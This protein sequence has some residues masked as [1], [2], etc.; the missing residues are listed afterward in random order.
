MTGRDAAPQVEH[1]PYLSR[2]PRMEDHT[3][4]RFGSTLWMDTFSSTRHRNCAAVPFRVAFEV[5]DLR[6]IRQEKRA[7]AR[8]N[9]EESVGLRFHGCHPLH[10]PSRFR[11]PLR[12]PFVI[13]VRSELKCEY[14]VDLG[15]CAAD[16]GPAVGLSSTDRYWLSLSRD[17]RKHDLAH[18]LSGSR[19]LLLQLCTAER[20]GARAARNWGGPN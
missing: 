2:S 17:L 11:N 9:S 12:L 15:N 13:P 8:Y 20:K 1:R 16:P 6:P 3:P 19:Q 7:R 4:I 18:R 14:G 5:D 10:R